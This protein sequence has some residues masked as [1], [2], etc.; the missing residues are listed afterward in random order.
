MNHSHAI[1]WL[2]HEEARLIHFSA[3]N[4]AIEHIRAHS[5]KGHLHH[6]AGSVG[7][8]HARIDTEFFARIALALESTQEIL[9]VGPGTAK[10]E[11][12]HYLQSHQAALRQRV[13]GIEAAARQSDGQLLALARHWFKPV[14]RMKGTELR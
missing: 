7:S 5:G 8:G 4:H 10:D 13:L 11:F 2:D 1:V 12:G 6:R 14:D 9:V 3:E